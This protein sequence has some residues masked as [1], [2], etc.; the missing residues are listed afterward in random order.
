[1]TI[2]SQGISGV[3]VLAALSAGVG[4]LAAAGAASAQYGGPQRATPNRGTDPMLNAPG[5]NPSAGFAGTV[6]SDGA[7]VV[8]DQPDEG[9][10]PGEVDAQVPARDEV[11]EQ[12]QHR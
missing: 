10:D 12:A 6:F 5:L 4:L 9:H 11:A 2:R 3:K 8:Q 1:M 7:A